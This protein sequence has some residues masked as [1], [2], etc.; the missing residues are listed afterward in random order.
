MVLAICLKGAIIEHEKLFV[1]YDL[2]YL[3]IKEKYMQ[4]IKINVTE[5]V[6]EIFP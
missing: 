2:F 3:R 6:Y 1:T 4:Q 5:V